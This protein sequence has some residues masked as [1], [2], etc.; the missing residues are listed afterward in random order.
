M[1]LK[2]SSRRFSKR[3]AARFP[4]DYQLSPPFS[5]HRTVHFAIFLIQKPHV[6]AEKKCILEMAG[7]LKSDPHPPF[8]SASVQRNGPGG[9]QLER[10]E[11]QGAAEAPREEPQ[12]V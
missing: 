1:P 2:F 4:R 10:L 7:K 12:G 11:H 8:E 3:P 6:G 5:H 9:A